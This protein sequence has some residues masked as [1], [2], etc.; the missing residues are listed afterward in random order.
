M[1]KSCAANVLRK[2]GHDRNQTEHY[3][4]KEIIEAK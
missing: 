3:I 4:F 1:K 2:A